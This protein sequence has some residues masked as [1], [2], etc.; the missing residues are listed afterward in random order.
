MKK[1]VLKNEI[2]NVLKWFIMI[3]IPASI[4]LVETLGQIYGFET[5][6]IILPIIVS[7]A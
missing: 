6:T 7:K 5:Q 2:Y 3:F 4:T 1:L